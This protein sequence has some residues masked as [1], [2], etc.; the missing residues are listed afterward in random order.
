MPSIVESLNLISETMENILNF[1]AKDEA[2]SQDFQKYLEINNIEIETEKD[3]NNV[4]I[5]Y[6]LDMKMQN[7]LRVLEYYRRNNKTYDEIISA[8]Q[9]S[10]CSVFKVEKVLSNAYEAT[11]LTSN[12]KMTLIPMVK[13][14]H[15][16]QIGKYDYI[17]SRVIELDGNQYILEIYDIISEFDVYGA[18]TSAIK[19]MLQNPKIAH[20]KN[21]EKRME[22]EKSAE[23][24]YQKFNEYFEKDFIITTNKKID[25]LIEAF[26]NYRLTNEKTDYTELINKAPQN[27]YLKIEEFNCDD[28]TFMQTAIGGFSN[29]KEIYD[30]AL[31]VDKKRGLYIIPFFETFLKCFEE[32]IE[33]KQDCIKEFLTSDK[34]PPSVIKYAHDNFKIFFDISNLKCHITTLLSTK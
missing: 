30:I 24:F 33:G 28:K 22:L 29:H 14:S 26:N 15:L 25:E 32:E 34:I 17:L 11:C 10:I 23:N 7:G 21:E 16:K 3:F 18:T 1:I 2:L 4:I 8:L 19:Y 27:K 9:E 31:W 13:M 6:M 20:Y 5:Q 12:T